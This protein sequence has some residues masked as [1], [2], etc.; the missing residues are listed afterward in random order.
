MN[1]A[2]ASQLF[3]YDPET[4]LVIRKVSGVEVGSETS[5]G[6]LSVY[7]KG[8]NYKLHRVAW[9]LT[10]GDWPEE[11]IDHIN[12]DRQDNRLQN[13]RLADNSENLMNCVVYS[14]NKSGVK[15]VCWDSKRSKWRVTLTTG[16]KTEHLGYLISLEDAKAL[17]EFHR[18]LK[19]G[20]YTN[21]G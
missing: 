6:Y 21:H 19:H 11:F 13:L 12:G 7:R 16:K 4:G 8:K 17:I 1:W 2:E 5:D 14:N 15:G 9:L 3:S 10:Y 20:E 18:Q